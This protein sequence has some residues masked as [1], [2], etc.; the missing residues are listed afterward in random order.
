MVK[1]EEIIIWLNNNNYYTKITSGY[2]KTQ[3]PVKFLR[4]YKV[5]KYYLATAILFSL[6]RALF[7]LLSR[8]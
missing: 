2:K 4:S 5:K 8:R 3:K 6:I 1:S 7:P